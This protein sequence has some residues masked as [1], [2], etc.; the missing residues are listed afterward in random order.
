MPAAVKSLAPAI[1]TEFDEAF[2]SALAQQEAYNKHHYRP[3]TYLHKWWARRCG[4]TFR[5]ILKALVEDDAKRDFYAAGG[6]E[7]KVILDPMMGGGTTLHEAIRMGATV[8]GAD[9]DPLPIL[10]ARATLSHIPLEKIDDAFERI[11]SKLVERIG[12]YYLTKSPC[13]NDIC[14]SRFTILGLR[15]QCSCGEV[16]AV[17]KLTLRKTSDGKHIHIDPI[18]HN[19]LCDGEVVSSSLGDGRALIAQR[20]KVC[21]EC[22]LK[23]RELVDKLHYERYVPLAIFGRCA[24]HGD[25]FKA[26]DAIDRSLIAQAKLARGLYA[27]EDFCISAGPKTNNLLRRGIRCYLD[28]FTDRQLL[29][30]RAASEELA[31]LDPLLRLNF[32]LLISTSLDFNSLLCGYKGAAVNRAGAIRQTFVRHAYSIPDTALENNPVF[33]MNRSGTLQKLY[34]GRLYTARRWA[35]A[36]EE[37][38]LDG[39]EIVRVAIEGELDGGEE[40]TELRAGDVA[41]QRFLLFQ[42]N[43][44]ELTL[45]SNSVDFIVTDP[46]YY[47]S[48]QYGELAEFFHVWLRKLVGET[49]PERRPER[50]EGLAEGRAAKINWDYQIDDSAVNR[51][52]LGNQYEA[53][54]T[55]IFQEAHRVLKKE[56][57]R[58]VFTF[59]HW[60][61]RAWAELTMALKRAG[62]VLIN[63]YVVQSESPM[64]VH[65][66][67]Q[68]ALLHD[69][70]LVLGSDAA[71]SSASGD[72]WPLPTKIDFSDSHTFCQQCGSILGHL[73]NNN[74]PD[75][76][77]DRIWQTTLTQP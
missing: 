9:I 13:C 7:G 10:Q 38:W 45:P 69:V 73:L 53:G 39:D 70:I 44:A 22:G 54:L 49:S 52:K 18:T 26:P 14:D 4:T 8:V 76:E 72:Q 35:Q 29:Y 65:T 24:T 59:H 48:V 28:L 42:G 67:N 33:G 74:A 34:R 68:K 55:K 71:T 47:D 3:N 5:A 17:D 41:K 20:K 66:A 19:I 2:V 21:E 32:A 75:L 23:Y 31:K 12:R 27:K 63:R 37:R 15:K 46:P 6:L 1:D 50:V 61:P 77:I 11:H 56:N 16:I 58:F 64:S 30:L 36:P 51:H 60:K 62:F 43:S 40:I 57:G 25:F